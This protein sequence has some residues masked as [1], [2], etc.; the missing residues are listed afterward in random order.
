VIFFPLKSGRIEPLMA[1]A[2]AKWTHG[3]AF[4]CINALMIYRIFAKLAYTDFLT[5]SWFS[6]L[7]WTVWGVERVN[8]WCNCPLMVEGG[9]S[10]S[11]GQRWYLGTKSKMSG[12]GIGCKL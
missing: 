8:R 3:G 7:Y 10:P 1:L 11:S 2:L 6:N 9:K 4:Y 5:C 12:S